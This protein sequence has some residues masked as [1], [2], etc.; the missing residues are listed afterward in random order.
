MRPIISGLIGGLIAILLTAYVA[1]RVGKGG[2]PGQ[3]R[4]GGFMWAL[5]AGCLLLA[6]LPIAVTLA[7]NDKEFWAKVV[8]FLVSGIGA[9]YCFAEAA[10]VRGSYD[11]QG[12]QFHTPWTGTKT[13]AWHDLRSVEFLAS[14]SWYTLT[15]ASGRKIRLSQFLQSHLSAV[16]MAST[17]QPRLA[18]GH[19]E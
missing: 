8:L 2:E 10:L 6:F 5:A 4:Y 16:E 3:L 12:I 18:N 17:K 9:A 15:F 11:E 14:C 7:G 19:Y 13:E 1:S